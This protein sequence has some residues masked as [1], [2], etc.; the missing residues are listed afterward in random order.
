VWLIVGWGTSC[1][2]VGCVRIRG[3]RDGVS[4]R[5]RGRRLAVGIWVC[6]YVRTFEC[7]A[8]PADENLPVRPV[9]LVRIAAKEEPSKGEEKCGKNDV[10]A[11]VQSYAASDS[12]DQS[13]V[14][15]R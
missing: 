15:N 7:N 3:I 11:G 5:S 9:Q 6:L 13:D 2:G 1:F 8:F 12:C 14:D 4:I 10:Q